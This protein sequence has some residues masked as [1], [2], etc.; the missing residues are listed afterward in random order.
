M[1]VAPRSRSVA[2]AVMPTAVPAAEFSTTV[3]AAELESLMEERSL[4]LTPVTAMVKDW[5]CVE[6]SE[7][8]ALTVMVCSVSSS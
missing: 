7:E 3:L 1:M 6:P 5:V 8:T 4:S 2:A